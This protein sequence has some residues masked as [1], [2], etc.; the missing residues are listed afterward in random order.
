MAGKVSLMGSVSFGWLNQVGGFQYDERYFLDPRYRLEQD[1]A[2]N[3]LLAERFPHDPIYNFEAHC[4]RWEG[5]LRPV[6]LVGG[7][8]TNLSMGAAVGGQ[9]VFQGDKD[10]D[11]TQTPL[12]DITDIDPLRKIDWENTWPIDLLVK[13]IR[14]MCESHGDRYAIIP[15]FF[16]DTSGWAVT[17]GP[18]TTAQKLMGERVFTEMVDNPTFLHEFLDWIMES[19]RRLIRLFAREAGLEI[20]GVHLGVCSACMIG[21]DHFAEFILPAVNNFG[22]EFGPVKIHSCGLSDHLSEVF[23]DIKGLTCLN[24]GSYSSVARIREH[25]GNVRI[26]VIPDAQLLTF[27]TPADI[28]KWTRQT[29]EENG[30]GQ[31][32]FQYHMDLLQPV[33][34]CLQINQTLR[35]LD[36]DCSRQDVF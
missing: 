35:E 18:V 31:L 16:W 25:I 19:K 17:F 14:Q 27:G 26:D 1:E 12:A 11:I 9:F 10:I 4:V 5:R 22:E 15:P 34:N 20:A 30:E 36:F 33:E 24:V 23:T 21:P 3:A 13:Q 29:V 28:D 7:I 32:E 6:A 2:V 8:Q